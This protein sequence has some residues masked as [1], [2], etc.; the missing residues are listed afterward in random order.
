MSPKDSVRLFSTRTIVAVGVVSAVSLALILPSRE[1]LL[2]LINES[3]TAD[4]SLAFLNELGSEKNKSL[5][6]EL[7]KAKNY[8]AQG[9]YDNSLQIL[10]GLLADQTSYEEYQHK[11]KIVYLY[12][13]TLID[14]NNSLD[15]QLN[16]QVIEKF[17]YVAD[18]LLSG[19][20]YTSAS[21][22]AKYAHGLNKPD[23]AL[24]ILLPYA[25][26]NEDIDTS[27]LISL[28][29]ESNQ[30]EKAT[31]LFIEV[32]NKQETIENAKRLF[33]LY[34]TANQPEKLEA[35]ISNYDGPL[36][37]NPEF[38]KITANYAEKSGMLSVALQNLSAL[39]VIAPSAEVYEQV[40]KLALANNDLSSAAKYLSRSLELNPNSEGYAQL[41]RIYLWM[42][43]ILLAQRTSLASIALKPTQDAVRRGIIESKALAHKRTQGRLY[44]KLSENNWILT[45]EYDVWIDA[46]E[47]GLGNAVAIEQVLKLLR[48][49]SGDAKLLGHLSRLYSYGDKHQLVVNTLGNI[50]KIRPL[51]DEETLRGAYAFMMLDQGK[52]ALNI[53]RRGPDWRKESDDYIE[54]IALLAYENGDRQLAT[55][56]MEYLRQTNSNNFDLYI[57]VRLLSPISKQTVGPLLTL[58]NDTQDVNMLTPL[59]FYAFDNNDRSLFEELII[60]TLGDEKLSQNTQVLLWQA[61]YYEMNTQIAELRAAIYKLLA[62]DPNNALAINNLIWFAIDN[63][64][65]DLLSELYHHLKQLDTNESEAWL[66]MASASDYLGIPADALYWYDK[67]LSSDLTIFDDLNSARPTTL[68]KQ[69]KSVA[70]LLNYASLLQRSGNNKRAYAIRRYLLAHQNHILKEI[71]GGDVSYRSLVSI[72]ISPAI[73]KQMVA[74]NVLKKGTETAI[75]ELF[76]QNLQ[77]NQAYQLMFWQQ[78]EAFAEFEMPDWQQLSLALKTK[79]HERIT[80]LLNESTGLSLV[81]RYTAYNQTGQQDNAWSLGESNLGSASLSNEEQSLLRELH[82]QQH[83]IKTHEFALQ[84]SQISTWDENQY[85]LEYYAPHQ[86]GNY[87]LRAYHS[88][89]DMQNNLSFP[90]NV[91]E[92]GFS[93]SYLHQS[94]SSSWQLEAD[95]ADGVGPTR[96]GVS[97]EYD[98]WFGDY[99]KA[100]ISAGIN[101]PSRQSRLM[102]L[103]GK[104]HEL[105]AQLLFA[106]TARE[107]ISLSGAIKKFSTRFDEDI[108]NGWLINIRA[109]ENLFI[110]AP[111]FQVYA[112]INVQNN[113]F[114][115]NDLQVFNRHF[116]SSRSR[117]YVL[118]DF[119]QEDF[120][121]F[122][123]GQRISHGEPGVAGR[124]GVSP[125]YWFDSSIGYNQPMNEFNVN[126]SAGISANLLGDDQVYLKVDWQS[127]DQ[128]G[129]NYLYFSM[130]YFYGL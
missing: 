128:F 18:N 8:L 43:E 77:D 88:Q 50:E 130:G 45:K 46:I 37:S 2:S 36:R 20:D 22:I 74:E 6:V 113:N 44:T 53:L 108:A 34:T 99:F 15:G 129:E 7:S 47:K 26:L 98:N 118:S 127:A 17:E 25:S 92:H 97:G 84:H 104:E 38:L 115:Q 35:F 103:A 23:L 9:K 1:K 61:K 110:D 126:L 109:T 49:R 56:T 83:P 112:D 21:L 69:K 51:N 55:Q 59:L 71:D 40:S 65:N 52:N 70:F 5:D 78:H 42:G 111:V 90:I 105:G 107:N 79:D 58:Y 60:P 72:L 10:D 4:I 124:T 81:D 85:A 121:R 120:R 11:D 48:L 91:S 87:R 106:P 86:S 93:A 125:N 68:D 41:N 64:Q 116:D 13:K 119:I 122:S 33:E 16:S 94:S 73:A 62:L 14:Q 27:K 19:L 76:A 28:A 96:F 32:F 66:A 117:A 75:S 31:E 123:I 3:S 80:R 67:I 29:L 95:I 82:V 54:F 30:L 100:T 114:S 57:Y 89:M 101:Q 102:Y 24:K 12:I 63:K 39:A